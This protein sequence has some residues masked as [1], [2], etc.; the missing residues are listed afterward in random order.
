[1]FFPESSP[2][3]G[4]SF[5]FPMRGLGTEE[6]HGVFPPAKTGICAV[7]L[8]PNRSFYVVF[9]RATLNFRGFWVQFLRPT[10]D[11][12]QRFSS[13]SSKFHFRL[14]RAVDVFC[15]QLSWKSASTS[16]A[17]RSLK[18]RFLNTWISR[19]HVGAVVWTAPHSEWFMAAFGFVAKSCLDF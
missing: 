17:S 4:F 8:F 1:M 18:L 5:S 19:T 6:R 16:K 15:G 9:R 10:T 7:F 2:S 11:P 12:N 14:R 13:F 3:V